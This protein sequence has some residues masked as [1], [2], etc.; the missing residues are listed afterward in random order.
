M[1]ECTFRISCGASHG[2]IIKFEAPD[3]YTLSDIELILLDLR[4]RF[5]EPEIDD[6]TWKQYNEYHLDKD[7][8][9]LEAIKKW[10]RGKEVPEYTIVG[11]EKL[12]VIGG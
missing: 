2:V 12:E 8:K 11:I 1:K 9:F 5:W 10:L 7:L 4:R 6:N 3:H